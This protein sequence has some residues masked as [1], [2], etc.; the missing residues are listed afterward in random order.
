MKHFE[1]TEEL[2]HE[3]SGAEKEDQLYAALSHAAGRMGFD[4][5]ALAFDRRG[6]GDAAS[7]LVH[8]YPDA[9]ANVYV[10]FDLSGTDPI[11]RASERSLTGFQWRDIDRYIPL[12]R[13]DRQLLKVARESGIGDGYTVPRH[14]P[15]EAT[16]TC[17]FAVSP[18][19]IIPAEM[20]HVAEIGPGH[21]RCDHR[22]TIRGP[23]TS[24]FVVFL[25]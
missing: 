21:L 10:G 16:G 14:L 19:T 18:K 12:S 15:G 23:S 13:G 8:N 25:D 6:V 3:I 5:F 24:K 1:L 9:W 7:M 20:L 17:S 11:R 2:A 4:L 22:A